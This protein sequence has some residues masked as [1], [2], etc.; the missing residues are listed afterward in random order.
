M[1]TS[2]SFI[3][4]ANFKTVDLVMATRV[5]RFRKAVDWFTTVRKLLNTDEDQSLL[6]G[7]PSR[8]QVD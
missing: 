3:F 2:L 4:P 7:Q 1:T 6:L 5:C 8:F